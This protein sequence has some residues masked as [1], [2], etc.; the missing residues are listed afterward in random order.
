LERGD[1]G[2][3]GSVNGVVLAPAA[4]EKLRTRARGRGRGHVDD[5]FAAGEQPRG[6]VA[7]E[8]FGVLNCPAPLRPL[9]RPGQ[10]ASVLT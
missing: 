8:T 4:A 1:A 3:G 2:R 9:P 6:E 7:A 5:V 10:H